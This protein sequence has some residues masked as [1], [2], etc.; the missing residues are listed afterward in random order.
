[1]E[2]NRILI[3]EFENLIQRTK[4]AIEY[5]Q[6]NQANASHLSYKL[7][8]FERG[9]EVILS[10]RTRIISG[11]T[12]KRING[13]GPGIIRRIDTILQYGSL[14]DEYPEIPLKVKKNNPINSPNN[15]PNNSPGD[16][17]SDNHSNTNLREEPQMG[18][19]KSSRK[20]NNLGDAISQL[21]TQN[22]FL[23]KLL[24]R[25][26]SR[27][28]QMERQISKKRERCNMLGLLYLMKDREN[29][30]TQKSLVNLTNILMENAGLSDTNSVSPNYDNMDLLE[31]HFKRD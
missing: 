22:T 30:E 24:N 11:D 10:K 2:S 28:I 26:H 6:N 1:M 21:V 5:L 13:I 9:L 25:E 16:N 23:V 8:A 31:E 3:K 17:S 29:S 7:N 12:L 27:Q 15:S 20:D 19:A 18:M 14:P 4:D